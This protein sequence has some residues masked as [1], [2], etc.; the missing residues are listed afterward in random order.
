MTALLLS[1]LMVSADPDADARAA[2]A[3][4]LAKLAIQPAPVVPVLPKSDTTDPLRID[5]YAAFVARIRTGQ[6]GVL[7]VGIEDRWVNTYQIHCRV[8]SLDGFAPGNY[9]CWLDST[10]GI[11][12]MQ[13]RKETGAKP[14]PFLPGT[15]VPRAGTS[16]RPEQERG[17]FG[18]GTVA[19]TYTL[20]PYAGSLGSTANCTTG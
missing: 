5:D 4:E 13:L 12:K 10:T 6:R 7:V 9:D 19:I 2:V 16:L 11:P 15:V 8:D 1:L 20:A 18:A 17:S 14:V 3:V